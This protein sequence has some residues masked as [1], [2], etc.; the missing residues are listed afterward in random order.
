MPPWFY[1][2]ER[3]NREEN[4]SESRKA[5]LQEHE[6]GARQGNYE[7]GDKN[8][9][10]NKLGAITHNTIGGDTQDSRSHIKTEYALSN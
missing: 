7:R 1:K 10:N 8:Y 9:L 2:E 6:H 5:T 4:A 3:T